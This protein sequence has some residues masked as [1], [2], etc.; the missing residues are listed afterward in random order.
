M[1]FVHDY[2]TDNLYPNELSNLSFYGDELF[3]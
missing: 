1:K 3:L 2:G